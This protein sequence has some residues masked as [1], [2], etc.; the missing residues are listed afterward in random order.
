MKGDGN[1]SPFVLY[2]RNIYIR[3]ILCQNQLTPM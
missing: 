3:G 2:N 1:S